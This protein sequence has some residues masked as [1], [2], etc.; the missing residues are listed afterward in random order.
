[1]IS[2]YK[3]PIEWLKEETGI[4]ISYSVVY[5]TIRYGLKDKLK[6][7]RPQSHKQQLE[8]KEEF[9]KTTLRCD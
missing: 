3:S 9:K 6:V 2:M 4:N 7:A 1:M 8:L 5:K